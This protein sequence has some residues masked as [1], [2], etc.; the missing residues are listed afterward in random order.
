MT[1]ADYLLSLKSKGAFVFFASQ[2]KAL[3]EARR[4]KSSYFFDIAR[5]A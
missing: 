4:L 5:R 1:K 2:A 3:T